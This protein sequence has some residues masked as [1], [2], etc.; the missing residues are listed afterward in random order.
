MGHSSV[1]SPPTPPAFDIDFAVSLGMF[2]RSVARTIPVSAGLPSTTSSTAQR[3]A[4]VIL[5]Q[6]FVSGSALPRRS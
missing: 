1:S 5:A 2:R 4:C 3:Q 6:S